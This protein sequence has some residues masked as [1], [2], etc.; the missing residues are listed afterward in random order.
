MNLKWRVLLSLSL[1][2]NTILLAFLLYGF[3]NRPAPGVASPEEEGSA[4]VRGRY[5][6]NGAGSFM[7]LRNAVFYWND[8]VYIDTDFLRVK[9]VPL[10]G[11]VTDMDRPGS[12]SM[13]VVEGGAVI[14]S[15]VL[16]RLMNE[17]VFNRD[18]SSVRDI[19][20]ATAASPGGRKLVIRGKVD[21]LVWMD[22]EM[23]C[24]ISVD[25]A[26]NIVSIRAEDVRAMGL[27][28]A[29]S[30]LQGL[31]IS[32]DSLVRVPEGCG[33]TVQADRI[34]MNPFV[35]FREPAITG[36]LKGVELVERGLRVEFLRRPHPPFPERIA[37]A[38]NDLLAFGGDMNFGTM[39][40]RRTRIQIVDRDP[41]DPFLFHMQRYFHQLCGSEV[42]V[43]PDGSLLVTMPD[44]A[45][46]KGR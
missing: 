43:L 29:G 33:V 38:K 19:T 3:V 36:R 44:A 13:D 27:P 15:P 5:A 23:T 26:R 34:E 37:A 35:L 1:L 45:V 18:G 21:I 31:G 6:G 24:G 11:E 17:R 16:S 9:S 25:E 32:L 20:A 8:R 30:L 39:M 12:F 42:R 22:F 10:A 40:A 14:D 28:F 7:E 46:P 2:G 4:L 41:S